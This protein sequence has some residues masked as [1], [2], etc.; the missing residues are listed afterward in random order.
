MQLRRSPL[1]SERAR[2]ATYAEYLTHPVFR[3]ARAVAI[4]RADGKC[5][6]PGCTDAATEVHHV[7]YPAWG[8]FDVP[9][10][11]RPVCHACHC[12]LEGK[13]S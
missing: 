4:H 12:A 11:L 5:Q 10:N 8:S 3:A 7:D 6:Q 13:A 1:S 9:A 2:Y